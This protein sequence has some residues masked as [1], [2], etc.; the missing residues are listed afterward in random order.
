MDT[1]LSAGRLTKRNL[2]TYTLG[3][4]GRDTAT[5]LWSSYL[6]TYVLFT[7]TLTNSQFAALSIIMVIGRAIDGFNDPIM[8]NILEITRTRWGKFKPW[9]LGGM[10]FCAGIYLVSFSNRLDGW[11][12]VVFFGVL[13]FAYDLVFTTNDIAYWGMIPSLAAHKEDRDLLTSRTVLFAGIGGAVATILIP[14]L[15]AGEMAI[16][17]NAITA[18]RT[19]AIIFSLCFLGFQTITLIGVKEKPL[20]PKGAKTI[21]NV[22]LGPLYRTI[23]NNDQLSWA[24]LFFL[25]NTTGSGI[26]NG[27]FGMNYIYFE[28]GYNGF[29]FTVFSALGAVATAAVMLFFTPISKRFTRNQLMKFAIW[30]TVGGYAMLLLVGLLVPSAAMTLKFG[31]LMVGNLFA[32]AGQNVAY[33]VIMICIANTVEYNEWKTGVRAE[34]IIFSIRPFITKLGWSL[35]S[36]IVMIAFLA[37]GVREFTNKI[38]AL[39]QEGALGL[40][41]DVMIARIK[42]VLAS[43]PSGKSN[44]LLACMT[45]IP[46]VFALISYLIYKK[47]YVI[48][49]ERY[50]QML[51]ELEERREL[52]GDAF[53]PLEEVK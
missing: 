27:G 5:T 46:V 24:I 50:D 23:R 13:Y 12:Y 41:S 53:A 16:G 35:I 40:A 28:F 34:G 10:I 17:G 15:T 11:A 4:I 29:L 6:F 14:P 1:Q 20:P 38:A 26:I 31:L 47:K 36:L 32:F 19:M 22:G 45:V 52:V 51:L 2:W 49:E 18:Y 30:S 39:E 37:S 42:D 48:T 21:N 33:L 7:K 3:S 8:G 9:I 44:A 43:V 25:F